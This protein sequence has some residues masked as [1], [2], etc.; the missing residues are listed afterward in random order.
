MADKRD[1]YEVLGVD[2]GA[3]EDTIK[4]AYRTQARKY[5]PDLHP[6]DTACEEKF[7]EV[8]EAYE[9]LSDPE[10]KSNYDRFGHAGVD[11]SYG[12]MGGMEGM[13]GGFS[14]MG[15]LFENLFGGVFGGGM[16]SAGPNAPRQGRDISVGVNLSFMEACTGKRME[17]KI[18]RMEKC[19]D[20]NGNGTAGGAAAEVCRDCQGRGTIRV[21]QRTPFGIMPQTKTCPHCGGKGK[22]ITNPC[23]KCRGAGRVRAPKTIMV[24][25]PAGIDNGQTLRVS[26][27]G[28]CGINGGPNGNLNVSVTVRPHP[29]FN[30][31]GYDVHCEIPLTYMQAVLG[32]EITVPTIDGNVKYKVGEGTQ[33]GTIFRLKGKGIQNLPRS[34]ND[35]RIQRG[36]QYVKVMVEVPKGLTKK[37]KDLLK[38]F[39]ASLTEKNYAKRQSFFEKIKEKLNS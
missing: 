20:C 16:R 13:S 31:D 28:D 18:Q 38:Q 8:T 39:E 35:Q 25:V 29:I 6:G 17:V 37:Q 4:K 9:V 5:H 27:Q 21:S 3:D 2:K 10:K 26:G 11:P 32:D 12:G 23:G 36:D 22:V 19:P 34:S 30:R 15:D 33:T 7:K 24:D 14:D 1:Y